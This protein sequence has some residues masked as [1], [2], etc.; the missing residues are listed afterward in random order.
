M[1]G[2]EDEI[3]ASLNA[4][5]AAARRAGARLVM[6]GILPTLR[7]QDVH[8]G[9]LSPNERFKVLNE[10]IFAARGEDMRIAIEGAEQLLAHT[11][12]ITPEAACT[13]VQLHLQVSPDS[14]ASYWNAAQAIAGVQVALAANSPFLF[15][16]QL[17]H[18]LGSPCSSRPPIPGQRS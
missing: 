7:Q 10:Q 1:T 6:I 2:L 16:R 15:G 17:W 8:E 11:D 13:S 4:A 3:R 18:E 12:S 9:T 14:F 5:D